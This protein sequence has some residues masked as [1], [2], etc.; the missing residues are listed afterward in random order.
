M[1]FDMHSCTDHGLLKDQQFTAA[2]LRHCDETAMVV[3]EEELE[4]SRKGES[5][6]EPR[7]RQVTNEEITIGEF[8]NTFSV[9]NEL[10]RRGGVII[11]ER[12][13]EPTG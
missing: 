6:K 3:S 10:G 5:L 11:P 8:L 12:L 7:N 13:A 9:I 2:T 4:H 1:W